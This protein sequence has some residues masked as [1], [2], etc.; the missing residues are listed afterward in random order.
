MTMRSGR[1]VFGV[2]AGV[3]LALGIVVLASSGLN[4]YG[5]H[6]ASPAPI[7]FMTNASSIRSVTTTNSSGVPVKVPASNETFGTTVGQVSSTG[8]KGQMRLST[9]AV[10]A[11]PL[12]Q[13]SS[14]ARQ[15]ITLT[16]FVLLPVFAA[17][18]FG[19]VVYRIS[20]AGNEKDEDSEAA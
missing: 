18:L 4:Q 5:M 14:I 11:A 20:R 17:L 19:F 8:Q 1:P 7:P 10:G 12:S 16:G 6:A 9:P 2:V 3:L 13:V 15:S